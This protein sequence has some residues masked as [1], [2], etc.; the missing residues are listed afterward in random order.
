MCF[1]V[2]GSRPR[3][4]EFADRYAACPR[5]L[6]IDVREPEEYASGHLPGSR[7][8]PLSRIRDAAAAVGSPDEPVYLYCSLGTRSA[9]AERVLRRMGLKG[10]VSIGGIRSY[11]GPLER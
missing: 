1:P 7:N 3:I 10:A 5:G 2:F 8:I 11:T 9:R 4:S 6:L